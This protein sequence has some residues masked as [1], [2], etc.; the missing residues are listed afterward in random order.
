M[1]PTCHEYEDDEDD[2][3]G[4]KDYEEDDV[5]NAKCELNKH[6]DEADLPHHRQG[7]GSNCIHKVPAQE[8]NYYHS[9][10]ITTFGKMKI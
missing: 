4:N 3:E 2:N 9:S 6:V 7:G 5:Y 1:I 8:K 10:L